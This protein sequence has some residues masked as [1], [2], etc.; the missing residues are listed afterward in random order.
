MVDDDDD[1]DGD[2]EH[3]TII[4]TLTASTYT[5]NCFLPRKYVGGYRSKQKF[6]QCRGVGKFLS[7]T[8]AVTL[9]LIKLTYIHFGS[10]FVV[11]VVVVGGSSLISYI[12]HLAN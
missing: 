7:S 1:D 5:R 3:V 10:A 8:C 6:L 12:D 2:V 4:K 11:V 9:L